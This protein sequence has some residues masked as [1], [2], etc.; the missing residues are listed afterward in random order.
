LL[1]LH[2]DTL[3]PLGAVEK[4]EAV[5]LDPRVVAGSFCLGFDRSS[6]LLRSYALF[7]KINHLLFTYG[8]QAL[9]V[10]SHAFRRAGGFP[11]L[12]IMEDV[13]IQR[14]LRRMGKFIKIREPVIT[15]ARRFIR[16]GIL[17]QQVLNTL[18]VGLYHFGFS[19]HYLKRFYR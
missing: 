15:S 18:L 3:L 12:P 4:I 7:S 16:L 1:F 5:M 11:D 8:D 19:P 6:F 9:F 10:S 14:T 17:R 13:G 2:A